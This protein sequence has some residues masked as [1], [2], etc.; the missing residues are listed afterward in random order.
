MQAFYKGDKSNSAILEAINAAIKE[1]K[2]W[3]TDKTLA[4]LYKSW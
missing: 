1:I 4:R 2:A 3:E